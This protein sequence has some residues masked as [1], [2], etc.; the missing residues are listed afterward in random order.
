MNAKNRDG[1]LMQPSSH[2]NQAVDDSIN[3]KTQ[4]HYRQI[5][6]SSLFQTPH[7]IPTCTRS[8]T[9]ILNPILL[10]I[11]NTIGRRLFTPNVLPIIIL[12]IEFEVIA[13]RHLPDDKILLFA[14]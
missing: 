6:L 5:P 1:L 3:P 10:T 8:S 9:P 4:R 7:T 2:S 14:L 12:G 11:Q 13:P